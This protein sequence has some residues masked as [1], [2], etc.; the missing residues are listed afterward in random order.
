MGGKVSGLKT[1]GMVQPPGWAMQGDDVSDG[2]AMCF[3]D[4]KS[5]FKG[6]VLLYVRQQLRGVQKGRI[7]FCKGFKNAAAV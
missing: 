6:S 4:F 2:Q 7:Y 5:V 1:L 3:I